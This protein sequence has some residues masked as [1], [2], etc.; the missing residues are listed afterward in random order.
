LIPVIRS[1]RGPLGAEEFRMARKR[2]TAGTTLIEVL[3]VIVIF[4]VGILA[5]VQI[6]PRGLSILVLA[7]TNSVANAMSRDQVEYLKAH[8]EQLPFDIVATQADGVTVNP[9]RNPQDLGPV[10]GDSL[11]INGLLHAGASLVGDWT[12]FSGP[13]TYR[14]VLGEPHSITAPRQ[15]G[16]GPGYYGSLV[17]ATFGPTEPAPTTLSAYG[18]D[19]TMHLGIPGPQD[20]RFDDQFYV[21]NPNDG[22]IQIG[23]PTG[24]LTLPNGNANANGRTYYASFSAYVR[25]TVSGPFV[26][27]DFRMVGIPTVP[28]TALDANGV[29]PLAVIDVSA[30]VSGMSLA[31]VDLA[32]LR[33]TRGY[34][35]LTNNAS[36]WENDEPFVYKV[37]NPKLGVFLFSPYAFGQYV[38]GP[39]GREPMLARLD[40]NVYDWRIL[41]EEFRL[42]YHLPPQHQLAVGS[43][44]VQGMDDVDGRKIP[45]IDLLEDPDL[46]ETRLYNNDKTDNFVLMDLDTGGVYYE[47]DPANDADYSG[48]PWIYLN[49]SSGVVTMVDVDPADGTQAY[50]LMPDGTT[51]KVTVDSRAVRA[52]YRTRNEMAVQV[53]KAAS[54]YDVSDSPVFLATGHYYVGGTGAG[55]S[56][57]RIYFPVADAGQSVTFGILNYRTSGGQLRQLLDQQFVI[58]TQTGEIDPFIDVASVDPQATTLDQSAYG[59]AARNVKGSSISVRTLWNPDTFHLGNNAANNLRLLDTWGRGWRRSTNETFLEQGEMTR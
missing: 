43:I 12:R 15:V 10:A 51:R 6:F 48:T 58:R 8:A 2:H 22:S 50:L 39:S 40:Y 13:N 30:L 4:L 1:D 55:G 33:V 38:S 42:P 31:S 17:I 37:L 46:A 14:R 23:L 16:T 57:T 35:L 29:Q 44:K 52:L 19:L 26:R 41:R 3:V 5:V 24:P 7:R 54:S 28:P 47:R 11:D 21:G 53:F 34:T 45:V 36:D 56:S 9:N 49:K 27:R 18:N 32:T 20:S 25:P 59:Y